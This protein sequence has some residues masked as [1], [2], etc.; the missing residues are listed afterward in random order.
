MKRIVLTVV[1]GLA[2]CAAP[3]LAQ[4]QQA[5]VTGGRI[6]GTVI[7]GV[8]EFK[9][10]PF[11]APPVGELRWKA[12]QPVPRWS[13][14]RRTQAFGPACIQDPGQA[15]RMAPGV[16]LSEDCLF[17]DVWTP[18]K[19]P[20]EKLPVL[21]WI[22][23]GGFTGGMTS[24]PLY[25]GARF[26]HKG[27][28]LVSISYRVGALGFLATP[29]LSRE[30]G[31]GSGNYG[32]LDQ[33]AG[34][35]WIQT[36]ISRLG[37]DPSR[38]T[39]LGHSAGAFAVSM[40]AGSALAK[41][42]FRGVIAESG[43]NFAP[44]QDSPW[45][46]SSARTLRLAEADGAEWLKRQGATTLAQARALP[47]EVIQ[48]AQQGTRFWPPVDGYVIPGDQYLQWRQ[49]RFSDTPILVGDVS[50]E[51][52]GFGVRP[53][54]PAAFEAEVRQGFG[55][56]ADAILAAYPHA[57]PEQATRARTLLASDTTF[58]WNQY[59]W[60]RLQ[61]GNGKHKAFVYWF[62]R[63]SKTNP[64][65]SGHGQEV[66]YVFGNL[67]VGGRPAP[68][69]EDLAISQQMQGYWVNFVATGDPNGPGLPPWPAFTEAAPQVLRIGTNPGPAPIPNL[70]RLQVLDAYYSWRR[71]ETER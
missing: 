67:G 65:G 33:L 7:D 44:P 48:Q 24:A 16:P 15:Q 22:Y 20:G 9:G 13:G 2:A 55:E 11:A 59:T 46:G 26:A 28:V 19:K 62:D 21:A 54:E 40:L 68:T 30:S 45:A 27:V 18:A 3:A 32:L 53:V 1:L 58:E 60:A 47:A 35:K 37:G 8:A 56:K 64:N 43:S 10:I 23:G 4:I 6:A 57:T 39:V 50:D 38:V 25:D 17:L 66:G 69:E 71:G 70:D 51:A 34:L 31:H 36:N 5:D 42:L 12:P 41:G 61:S 29:E 63:P 52:A 14:V 49:G